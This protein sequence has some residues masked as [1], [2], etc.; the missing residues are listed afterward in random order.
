MCQT[1]SVSGPQF[2]R[3]K[4]CQALR[5]STLSASSPTHFRPS[6]LLVHF[7]HF[8]PDVFRSHID[9]AISSEPLKACPIPNTFKS[10][11]HLPKLWSKVFHRKSAWEEEEEGMSVFEKRRA[12][13]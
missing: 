8:G 6:D 1:L 12:V 9:Y 13:Q 4:V 5:V 2:V 3:P 10:T 7:G 11:L